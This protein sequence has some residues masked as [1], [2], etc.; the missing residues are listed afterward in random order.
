MDAPGQNILSGSDCDRGFHAP[1]ALQAHAP[2]RGKA[3]HAQKG[4]FDETPRHLRP[5]LPPDSDH[6]VAAESLPKLLQIATL[7]A[8]PVT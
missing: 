7:Y 1:G 3:D 6:A 4:D 8:K 5:V 2:C